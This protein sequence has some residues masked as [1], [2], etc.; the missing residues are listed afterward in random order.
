MRGGASIDAVRFNVLLNARVAKSDCVQLW[1]NGPYWATTNIGA[2]NPTDFG[3]YF[4]WGDT[5]GYELKNGWASVKD[6]TKINFDYA[7][8]YA[9]FWSST[10]SESEHEADALNFS[11]RA[12][13]CY[14]SGRSGG[15]VV[16]TV[17]DSAQ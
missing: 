14:G 17:S 6:G 11:S 1:E 9:Y 13:G 4:W 3:Y 15:H 5:V 7:G 12:L 8:L 10:P 16:R 2:E